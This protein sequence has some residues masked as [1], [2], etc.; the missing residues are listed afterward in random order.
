MEVPH[1]VSVDVPDLRPDTALHVDRPRLTKLV[2]TGDTAGQMVAGPLEGLLRFLGVV[3]EALFFADRQLLDPG[4]VKSRCGARIHFVCSSV[5]VAFGGPAVANGGQ[6]PPLSVPP[7]DPRPAGAAGRRDLRWPDGEMGGTRGSGGGPVPDG[8]G[9][10]GHERRDLD[11]GRGF[12]YDRDDHSGS[13]RL[14]RPGH[15]R[16]HA[17]RWKARRHLRS[18][19]NFRG[20]DGHLRLRLGSDRGIWK[21]LHTDAR[22][23]GTGGNRRRHGP[24]GDG[25]PGRRKLRRQ[26]EGARLR[27]P[28]RRRRGRHRGRTDP[29][30][31][32]DHRT[33]LAGRIRR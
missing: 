8:S 27:S 9:P 16:P 10:G 31:L 21:R 2:G 15:G 33:Q 17:D 23:V 22:L 28:R 19:A 4:P 5:F 3:V 14:L 7:R 26:G 11:P 6:N 13:Y 1:L 25:G 30:R 29:R 20:R 18:P 12:R 24:A 32:G